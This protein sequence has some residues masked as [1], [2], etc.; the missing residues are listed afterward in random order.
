MNEFL[1]KGKT[2]QPTLL[3]KA[4]Q[5]AL[6]AGSTSTGK[7]WLQSAPTIIVEYNRLNTDEKI[8]L[9]KYLNVILADFNLPLIDIYLGGHTFRKD[10]VSK[11]IQRQF[12]TRNLR[13]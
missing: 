8:Y 12:C 6:E 3:I 4:I 10:N 7:N 11:R 13:I 2:A 9:I 1:K 5:S